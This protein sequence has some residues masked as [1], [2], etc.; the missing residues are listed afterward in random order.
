MS[1]ILEAL[2]KAN[3]TG[4]DDPTSKNDQATL[5]HDNA[6]G[7]TFLHKSSSV[8][9]NVVLTVVVIICVSSFVVSFKA[10]SEIKRANDSSIAMIQDAT[11]QKKK[12]STIEKTIAEIKSQEKLQDEN[13]KTKLSTL[14][15][16]FRKNEAKIAELTP[17]NSD[18]RSSV[19]D[20]KW[21]IQG[22]KDKYVTISAQLNSLKEK[23]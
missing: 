22:L 11:L 8:Y 6:Q 3:R 18:L 10:L 12:L 7:H 16:S 9:Q 4:K 15:T 17:V 13:F 23:Q 1:K 5:S 19:N 21:T 14:S 20:L 2:R